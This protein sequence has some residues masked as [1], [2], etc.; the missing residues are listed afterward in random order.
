MVED[1][2]LTERQQKQKEEKEWGSAQDVLSI[3]KEVNGRDINPKYLGELAEKKGLKREKFDERTY[4]YWLPGAWEI[5][6]PQ[7]EGAGNRTSHQRKKE[8][9]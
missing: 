9:D 1:P 2:H 3:L 8:Q 5:K 6:I 4:T 7:R